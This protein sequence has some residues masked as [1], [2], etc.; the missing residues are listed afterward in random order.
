[1]QLQIGTWLNL[2][3]E[4]H[5][6]RGKMGLSGQFFH[7]SHIPY[8]QTGLPWLGLGANGAHPPRPESLAD[9][10]QSKSVRQAAGCDREDSVEG[11]AQFACG[12]CLGSSTAKAGDLDIILCVERRGRRLEL[13]ARHLV[14]RGRIPPV[15]ALPF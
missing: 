11:N 15:S 5:A 7:A 9:K 12:R 8:T 3:R 6:R 13:E 14:D 10:G 1:M 2:K 4:L